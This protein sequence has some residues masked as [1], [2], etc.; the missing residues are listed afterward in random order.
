MSNFIHLY[1][2]KLCYKMTNHR[3]MAHTPS[4]GL[5]TAECCAC[6][7]RPIREGLSMNSAMWTDI[8]IEENKEGFENGA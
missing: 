6:K 4:Q 7:N 8:S 2:C 5:F 3:W 1:F